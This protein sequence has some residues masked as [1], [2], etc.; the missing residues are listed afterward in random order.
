[1]AAPV[2]ANPKYHHLDSHADTVAQRI[3]DGDPNDL[4]DAKTVA[5]V[6]QISVSW[7]ANAR[8]KGFGPPFV[9]LSPSNARYRRSDLLAWLASRTAIPDNGK[10]RVGWNKGVPGK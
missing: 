8:G 4:L 2:T 10:I 6:L 7:L 1:M 9:R 5:K 3:S